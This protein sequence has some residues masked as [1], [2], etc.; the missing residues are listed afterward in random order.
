MV[1]KKQEIALFLKEARLLV[2]PSDEKNNIL[3]DTP[4]FS[5]N[6]I[7]SH[8]CLHQKSMDWTVMSFPR[9]SSPKTKGRLLFSQL[10]NKT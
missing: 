5:R 2:I 10:L 1:T 3:L 6:K 9:A 4:V 8:D 7:S